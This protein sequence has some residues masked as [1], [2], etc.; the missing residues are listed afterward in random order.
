MVRLLTLLLLLPFGAWAQDRL[1]VPVR[2][3][4]TE[5]VYLTPAVKPVGTVV[6]FPG[7]S[8]VVGAVRNNFLLRVAPRFN[9]AGFNVAVVDTPSDV[10]GGMGWQFRAGAEHGRDV[11]AIVTAVKARFPAP[12]WLIGTSR[13]SVSAGNGA[14]VA[15]PGAVAGVVL[16]SS[17]WM[18]GMPQIAA[19]RIKVPVMIVHNRDDGCSESPFD[20]VEPFR[21]RLTAAPSLK[22]LPVS[23]GSSR[24]E[25]CQAMSPHG[26][27]GIED[28]AV[29]P[30]VAWMRG[31]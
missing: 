10:P 6:L 27:L 29:G 25:P 26:Y 8:G 4:V 24:S 17:V 2:P 5:P 7:G 20:G 21:A 11:A 30:I 15:G 12:L 22:F 9:E 18:R 13:G 28:Q 31:R 19:E 1:D 16:T 14:V 23:G 3:G